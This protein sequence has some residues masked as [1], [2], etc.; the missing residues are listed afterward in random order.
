MIPGSQAPFCQ[1]SRGGRKQ[2]EFRLP[3]RTE[4]FLQGSSLSPEKPLLSSKV[5]ISTTKLFYYYGKS[6]SQH[7]ESLHSAVSAWRGTYTWQ[8][9]LIAFFI[10]Q[11]GFFQLCLSFWKAFGPWTPKFKQAG[12]LL[13]ELGVMLQPGFGVESGF[14]TKHKDHVLKELQP[15]YVMNITHC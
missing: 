14:R 1:E 13:A 3:L 7:S 9:K 8:T 4:R 12:C 11:T 6:H 2:S 15:G 10:I 5:F